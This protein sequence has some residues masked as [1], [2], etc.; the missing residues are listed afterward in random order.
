[1]ICKYLLALSAAASLGTQLA[2]AETAADYF[3]RKSKACQEL[4]DLYTTFNKESEPLSEKFNRWTEQNNDEAFCDYFTHNSF[5]ASEVQRLKAAKKTNIC[6]G[7]VD[8]KVLAYQIS[9]FTAGPRFK[10]EHCAKAAA[11]RKDR[12]S[13][14]ANEKAA[15]SPNVKRGCE[16]LAETYKRRALKTAGDSARLAD[17]TTRNDN[18]ALCEFYSKEFPEWHDQYIGE[19]LK[20]KSKGVCWDADD[21]KSIEKVQ[22]FIG[23]G[24]TLRKGYCEAARPS[25]RSALSSPAV[26][27][28][29]DPPG[30]LEPP[31]VGI[32]RDL[33][34]VDSDLATPAALDLA[35]ASPPVENLGK[36]FT[37]DQVLR[38]QLLRDRM[39]RVDVTAP[40]R[41]N[42]SELA[43]LPDLDLVAESLVR[44]IKQNGAEK[45]LVE[46]HTDKVG[47]DADD[48]LLTRRLATAAL[49][50]L[51]ML[52]VPE[53][54]MVAQGYGH[55]DLKLN[56]SGPA[57]MNRRLTIRRITPLIT[58]R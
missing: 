16:D 20:A 18:A 26:P 25:T 22:T 41:T 32:P 11:K 43:G 49:D 36:A 45:F 35:L 3:E 21:Q 52:G 19:V 57:S 46:A 28:A 39:R 50:T 47:S 2:F 23:E 4:S 14:A 10:K 15:A 44:I 5:H 31:V 7:A 54:N 55:S 13:V 34:I 40:F 58:G 9:A 24:L 37:V 51:R 53:A 48:L 56:D 29:V 33:Y 6:W 38:S 42:R 8:E 30:K 1:M 12:S 17:W 27:A